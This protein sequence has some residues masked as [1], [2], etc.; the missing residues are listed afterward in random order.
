MIKKIALLILFTI[1]LLIGIPAGIVG[2]ESIFKTP[3]LKESSEKVVIKEKKEESTKV[4]DT[5]KDNVSIKVYYTKEKKILTLPIEEYIKLVVS[6]EMPA[7]F[8]DEALKAQSVAAR[9]FLIPKVKSLGGTPCPKANG[10]DVCSD[11]H[12][13]AFVPKEQRM[14]LWG[15]EADAK[16]KKVSSAV[17]ETKSK[18]LTYNNEIA[19]YIK[20]FS[21]SG[22]KTEDSVEV[23]GTAQPY[24]KSVATI[25][26]KESPNYKT[27][28][29][30]K[31]EEVVSKVKAKYK[32]A[33]VDA[34]NI[35]K[36]M[37]ITEKTAGGRVKSINIG[38][39]VLTGTEVRSLF[40]LKS[41]DFTL[42][43]DKASVVFYV[44][45]YGHGVGMSQWGAHEMGKQGKNY[46]EILKHYYT[47]ISI[48][49]YKKYIK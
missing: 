29:T 9:S 5:S 37:K 47:G 2:I 45:G 15:A 32:D 40:S 21:T 1:V 4:K 23:F 34:K 36:Q 14:K 31:R 6:S 16:W 10:A 7:S 20:Y 11:V 24:L 43:F 48:D 38:G 44:K 26:E 33:K 17:D 19:K 8:S 27:T 28:E 13:Q 18:V 41:A 30:F 12:C 46:T 35:D 25:E 49:D 22:G 42:G 3:S 39:K